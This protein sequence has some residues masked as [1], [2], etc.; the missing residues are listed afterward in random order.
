[1]GVQ[2]K[3]KEDR[4]YIEVLRLEVNQYSRGN[5][6]RTPAN[7]IQSKNNRGPPKYYLLV[8]QYESGIPKFEKWLV[9][10]KYQNCELAQMLVL[11]SKS[12]F[13]N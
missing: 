5:Q 11:F 9:V 4:I 13:F 1:M 10:L 6:K 7:I 3:A 2:L 8:S 12:V